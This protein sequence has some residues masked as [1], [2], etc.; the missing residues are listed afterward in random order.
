MTRRV[1][2]GLSLLELLVVFVIISMVSTVLIQ[3][4]GFGLALFDRVQQRDQSHR[5]FLMSGHWFRHVNSALIATKE[6][7]RSLNGNH[8]SFVARSANPLLAG[9]G[10]PMLISWGIDNGVLTYQEGESKPIEVVTLPAGAGFE[11]RSS[12]GSWFDYWPLEPES[13]TLPS[14]IRIQ[15]SSGSVLTVAV[16]TR[17]MP[18]LLLDESRRER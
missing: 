18:D 11:Y 17:L 2:S 8:S 12:S 9:P 5:L 1:E 16:K 4:F 10:L 7:G 15:E 13:Y 3:G 14:A 6:P